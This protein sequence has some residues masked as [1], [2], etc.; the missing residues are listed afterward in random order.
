MSWAFLETMKTDVYWNISYVQV[1]ICHMWKAVARLCAWFSLDPAKHKG[2]SSR[3]LF[4]DT[5]IIMRLS[6]R[7]EQP[8]PNMTAPASEDGLEL[9]RTITSRLFA[10]CSDQPGVG[11]IVVLEPVNV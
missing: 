2:S 9:L 1:S 4:P 3:K 8:I 10:D 5:S 11:S 7:P 6:A